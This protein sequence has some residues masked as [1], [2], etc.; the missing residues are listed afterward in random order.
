[1]CCVYSGMLDL[2]SWRKK[3]ANVKVA[4]I[5]S[6]QATSHLA[7]TSMKTIVFHVKSGHLELV[8]CIFM[9]T[10]VWHVKNIWN[11]LTNPCYYS[12]STDGWEKKRNPYEKHEYGKWQLHLPANPDGTCPIKHGSKI[13]VLNPFN[14]ILKQLKNKADITFIRWLLKQRMDHCW[15]GCL[16]GHLMLFSPQPM[17]AVH[18]NKWFGIHNKYSE[19]LCVGRT[20][21][22]IFFCY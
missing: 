6:R 18:T 22:I 21:V 16:H 9:E 5:N 10:L 2:K 1:M 12:I 3:F 20:I 17:K 11:P 19:D 14:I 4:L 15:I 8:I 13:K 7:F